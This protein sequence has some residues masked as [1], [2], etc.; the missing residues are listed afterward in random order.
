[1]Q[2]AM[3]E[4]VRN[5]FSPEA[6]NQYIAALAQENERLKTSLETYEKKLREVTALA[7]YLKQQSESERLRLADVMV[8]AN[9]AASGAI[10]QAKQ[11][12]EKVITDA[13]AEA[14]RIKA[15]TIEEAAELK[16]KLDAELDAVKETFD[17]I[18]AATET[19]RQDLLILF[20]KVDA[21]SRSA[22]ALLHI[23]QQNKVVPDAKIVANPPS[24]MSPET[25]EQQWMKTMNELLQGVPPPEKASENPHNPYIILDE[26]LDENI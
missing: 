5:G 23:W 25:N 14:I 20:Q 26:R 22:S 24:G 1:M 12:A 13:N 19:S 17:K 4:R 21:S 10:A 16:K 3:F 15:A 6:V 9:N 7:S 18:N 2:Q 11:E 8:Q